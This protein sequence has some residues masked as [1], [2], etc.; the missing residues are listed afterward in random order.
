MDGSPQPIA[1]GAN[2]R[3]LPGCS[4]NPTGKQPGTRNRA[5]LLRE[6]M[7][8]GDGHA[9]ARHVVERAVAGDA[10]AARFCLDRLEPK[11]RGRPI[12]LDLPDGV[13]ANAAV[14]AAFDSALRQ[15]AEG[16]ITPAEAVEISRFLESR[17]RALRAWAQKEPEI[18]DAAAIH[19][20]IP[21]PNRTRVSSPPARGEKDAEGWRGKA[22]PRTA[23]RPRAG[24]PGVDEGPA[25]AREVADNFSLHNPPERKSKGPQAG[26][27]TEPQA[28]HLHSA[29]ISRAPAKP[30][31]VRQALLGTA[32]HRWFEPD[33]AR[34]A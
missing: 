22:D 30:H 32:S 4:G 2:G 28:V 16:E 25:S 5:T 27:G 26:E 10:V 17:V 31:G 29:C 14:A 7:R 1:R 33:L 19:H 34:C 15:L 13:S 20:N 3:F 21:S 6:V 8:E 9:M 23:A 12:S 18:D 24:V 11:P